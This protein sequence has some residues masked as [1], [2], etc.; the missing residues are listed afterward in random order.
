LNSPF[1]WLIVISIF[2]FTQFLQNIFGYADYPSEFFFQQ[3]RQLLHRYPCY[4]GKIDKSEKPIAF[5][6]HATREISAY[7]AEIDEKVSSG[8]LDEERANKIK[9]EFSS[10]ID[11]LIQM[12]S[13]DE[14]KRLKEKL[15]ELCSKEAEPSLKS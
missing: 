9:E 3:A 6:Y 2:F 13:E 7:N 12:W 11:I 10:K 14:D 5:K 15:A 1:Q 8:L 4:A